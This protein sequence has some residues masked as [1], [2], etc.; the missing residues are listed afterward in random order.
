MNFFHGET[1]KFEKLDYKYQ[2]VLSGF[3]KRTVDLMRGEQ[4]SQI[5]YNFEFNSVESFFS[6]DQ[7]KGN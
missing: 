7:F 4:L 2:L 1:E 5:H 6:D 3:I